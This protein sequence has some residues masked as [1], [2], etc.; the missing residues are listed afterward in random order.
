MVKCVACLSDDGYDTILNS[1][2][3]RYLVKLDYEHSRIEVIDMGE[4]AADPDK[5]V[6]DVLIRYCPI[7]GRELGIEVDDG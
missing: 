6:T 5:V 3:Q 1:H 2:T 4:T 7:C